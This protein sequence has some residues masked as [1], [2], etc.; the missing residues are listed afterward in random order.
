MSARARSARQRAER[1][2]IADQFDAQAQAGVSGLFHRGETLRLPQSRCIRERAGRRR[3]K[4]F[5]A[6][7]ISSYAEKS[8]FAIG[9][10]V[11]RVLLWLF[12]TEKPR[13]EQ[14]RRLKYERKCTQ[15]P[16]RRWT[17]SRSPPHCLRGEE[18]QTN[19]GIFSP[20]PMKSWKS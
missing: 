10:A 8:I 2:R 1:F 19:S 14:L 15:R 18:C 11:Q 3:V 17:G 7:G 20:F 12:L 13:R 16:R 9:V 5:G 4:A 6:A